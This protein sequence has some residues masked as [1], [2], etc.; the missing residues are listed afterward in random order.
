MENVSR[1]KELISRLNQA[2]KV[3]YQGQGEVM[4]N[5][6]YD[7]LYDELLALEKETGIT[8]NNS[9]TIHVGYETIS[10]LPKEQHVQPMLSL[11]KTKEPADLV[12]W[13]GNEQGLLSMKLDGLSIILTY[14]NGELV[15][16]LTRGNG[17]IGE[18][19]TNNAKTFVNIPGRIQ[20]TGTLIVR[21][22]ALIRYSDFEELNKQENVEEQYKNP[23]NLCSGSV[24]QLNNEITAKRRVHFYAYN[25][26]SIGDE[27]SFTKKKEGLSWLVKQGFEV[28]PYREVSASN[29]EDM[30]TYFS[31]YVK[32]S[33]LPSDGLVLTFDDVAYSATLGR[34]AKFPHDSIA[35][36]WQDELAETTLRE[37]E[38]SASRTGL[39]NPVAVFDA[40][41]LEGTTVSR[42]SVHNVSILK[43]LKLGLGDKI[44]VYKAN[45]IIPQIQENKTQSG[46]CVIPDKCPACGASTTLEQEHGSVFLLCPNKEC[47][48]KKIKLLTHFVSR[49][50]MNIDGLSES[51]L[52]KFV[53]DGMIHS[54]TDI[55]YLEKYQDKIV[56]M[57]GFG[58]KSYDNLIESIEKAKQIPLA[59]LLYSLGIK[60]IGLSMAKL[61][62]EKYPYPITK[63]QEIT[64]EDL[65]KVDGIG[66]VL[67]KSFVR[68][69][70]DKNNQEQL[71]NLDDLL[72]VSYPEKKEHQPF[73]GLTFVITGT[74]N[75]FDNRNQCKDMIESLG[76][77]VAGSVSKN[78]S[79]LVNNDITSQSSKNKKAKELSVP[80]IEEATLAQMIEEAN[81][82]A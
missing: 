20:Y 56:E 38:W 13:L 52:E 23:R 28:A 5:F 24:R 66:E 43:E 70:A 73:A 37:I 75:T 9:P 1:M 65:L 26:I 59:N 44:L 41:E 6:E 51:T 18:V 31:N 4:S 82:K 10:E 17:E 42:A 53:A 58:E 27:I 57:E 11:N 33:D 15:K 49:N 48:A 78:T 34:T 74:L 30:I 61:I 21:G 63:M 39:I 79:Y 47:Y 29:I 22:E 71:K 68:Y 50:A 40:V 46:T 54:L 80:I 2:A 36:K 62:A 76:G 69:F 25:I 14:E 35:F 8:M 55:F 7:K 45:M 72:I 77:K 16:A 60:G 12:A 32:Q 67:A 81:E 3:Y 64:G 19:I